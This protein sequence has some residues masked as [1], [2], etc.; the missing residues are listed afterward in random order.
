MCI[1]YQ[2]LYRCVGLVLHESLSD[3]YSSFCL[4]FL[5]GYVRGRALPLLLQLS[6]RFRDK[7]EDK[8]SS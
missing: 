5:L 1:F 6:V 4:L 3:T 7:W 2:M 8:M